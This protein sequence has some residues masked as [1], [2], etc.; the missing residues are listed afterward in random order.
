MKKLISLKNVVISLA[1]LILIWQA[2][3]LGIS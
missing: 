1:A 3:V 2:L